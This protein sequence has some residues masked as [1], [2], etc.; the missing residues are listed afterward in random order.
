MKSVLMIIKIFII[1]NAEDHTF[2]S[3]LIND[4][5]IAFLRLRTEC[6]FKI[7]LFQQTISLLNKASVPL[8][9]NECT[10]AQTFILLHI[11]NE[12]YPKAT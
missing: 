5:T 9:V 4:N 7:L 3:L 10:D 11:S 8:N 12:A 1:K 2:H 6:T